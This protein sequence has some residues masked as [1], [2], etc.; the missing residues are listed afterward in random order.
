MS[1]R[2]KG[3]ISGLLVAALLAGGGIYAKIATQKLE[4]NYVNVKV[5]KDNILYTLKDQKG[6]TIE[7]FIYNG[8]TYLP[9]RAVAELAGLEVS[10]DNSTKSVYLYDNTSAQNQALVAVCKAYESDNCI[11]YDVDE[12]FTMGDTQYN[13]GIV[14]AAYL[15]SAHAK[16]NL[17]KK[18]KSLDVTVGH[19]GGY[20]D[21]TK[22]VTF[23]VDGKNIGTITIAPNSKPQRYTVNLFN[24]SD[25]KISIDGRGVGLGNIMVK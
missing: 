8:T 22:T 5:Y 15:T 16:F 6:N 4:V 23:V 9:V 1:K 19:K 17:Q 11:F 24:G 13:S 20:E 3:I 25:L 14:S 7:P 21:T 10:W 2:L 12:H 18:Y